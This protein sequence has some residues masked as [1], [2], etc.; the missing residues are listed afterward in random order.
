[1]IGFSLM[2]ETGNA[3]GVAVGD[4]DRARLSRR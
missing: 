2:P 4:S 1:M 3:T